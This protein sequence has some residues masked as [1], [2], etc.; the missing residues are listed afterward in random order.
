M[1]CLFIEKNI[2]RV[3]TS[4]KRALYLLGWCHGGV[5]KKCKLY[6]E[7]SEINKILLVCSCSN[8]EEDYTFCSSSF[9]VLIVYFN[10]FPP[11]SVVFFVD[12]EQVIVCWVVEHIPTFF[13]CLFC[14]LRTGKCL[15]SCGALATVTS[16]CSYWTTIF[17]CSFCSFGTCKRCEYVLRIFQKHFSVLARG[18]RF[19]PWAFTCLPLL[20]YWLGSDQ[21]VKRIC[22]HWKADIY[23]LVLTILITIFKVTLSSVSPLWIKI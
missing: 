14:W 3:L 1:P 18:C 6:W 20:A 15:L 22:D 19:E 9:G 2:L 4:Y 7:V 16:R 11:F 12:L 13:C 10:I 8:L 5:F 21:Y 17:K 23:S